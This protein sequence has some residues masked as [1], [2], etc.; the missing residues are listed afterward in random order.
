MVGVNTVTP[1]IAALVIAVRGVLPVSKTGL[2][3]R[4]RHHLSPQPSLQ[5]RPSMLGSLSKGLSLLIVSIRTGIIPR[6]SAFVFAARGILPSVGKW[7]CVD[8]CAVITPPQPRR[9]RTHS[10]LGSYPRRCHT[11]LTL[12]S[13]VDHHTAGTTCGTVAAQNARDADALQSKR[14]GDAASRGKIRVYSLL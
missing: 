9:C 10:T 2:R 13:Y 5:R 4:M 6:V 1:H 7:G 14:R 11:H 3:G 8:G 12:G